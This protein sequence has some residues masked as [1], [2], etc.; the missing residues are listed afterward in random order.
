MKTRKSNQDTCIDKRCSQEHECVQI[1]K[2]CT[3]CQVDPDIGYASCQYDEISEYHG[4]QFQWCIGISRVIAW[5]AKKCHPLK[6]IRQ[7]AS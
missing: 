1:D 5:S 7:C 2:D 4:Y 6:G 3:E